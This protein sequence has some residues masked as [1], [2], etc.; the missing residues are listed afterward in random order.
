[1]ETTPERLQRQQPKEYKLYSN[2]TGIGA[3]FKYGAICIYIENI[4]Q[5]TSF[6]SREEFLEFLEEYQQIFSGKLKY[7]YIKPA[8]KVKG[9]IF[10]LSTK[11]DMNVIEPALRLTAA[12]TS[13]KCEV[14]Y[15][16]RWG[17]YQVFYDRRPSG[18]TRRLIQ[19]HIPAY[20][21]TPEYIEELKMKVY[22][23]ANTCSDIA[24]VCGPNVQNLSPYEKLMKQ[25]RD[26]AKA[27]AENVPEG[28]YIYLITHE[29]YIGYAK[30]G[31]SFNDE[32]RR[33]ALQTM[34]PLPLKVLYSCRKPNYI[35]VERQ[36][37]M[38]Y[39]GKRTYGEWFQFQEHELPG[40]IASMSTT[41]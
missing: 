15:N 8:Y 33:K 30:I 37:H 9:I 5:Y 4:R 29:P 22:Y 31:R 40:V 1:M 26:A 39:A 11:Y 28:D 27:G 7:Y 38:L 14:T 34:G 20:A 21:R 35:E 32:Y 19:Q 25:Q 12:C 23:M 41:G 18:L 16:P 36:L 17:A 3:A 24:V 6:G 10:S 13:T 2:A